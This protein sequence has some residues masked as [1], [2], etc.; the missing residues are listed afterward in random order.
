MLGEEYPQIER[1]IPGDHSRVSSAGEMLSGALDGNALRVL[2]LGCGDGRAIDILKRMSPTARYSGVDIES[3]PEVASRRRTDGDFYT[4]DGTTLPF[5]DAS[6][7]VVFSQQVFEH[8]RHPDRVVRE[9]ERV[10]AP[11]G[12]FVGSVSY[13][14]PYHSYSI[15]NFTPY[16]VFRVVEDNGLHLREMRPG[17]EGLSLIARQ[18]TMRRI[19]RFPV[20]YP[21]IDAAGR[22][23]GWD[24]R[25]RNYLKLRLAGHICFDAEKPA[26]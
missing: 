23:K 3:S 10:L 8:V 7:D 22:V 1:A 6:F 13:L 25:R 17:V 20:A 21:M 15:F 18:V 4:Y 16:G 19:A 24:A 12:R 14:E 26:G 9:I 2:D 5:E 11:G